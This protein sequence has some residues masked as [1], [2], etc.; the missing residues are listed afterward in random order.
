MQMREEIERLFEACRQQET[1]PGRESAHEEFEYGRLF[2]AAVEIRLQHGELVEIGQQR[3][4]F[5]GHG[6]YLDEGPKCITGSGRRQ[7][8]TDDRAV[9]SRLGCLNRLPEGLSRCSIR[10]KL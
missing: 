8:P 1:A 3:A 10:K 4:G 6:V 7:P 5:D 9:I 2:H